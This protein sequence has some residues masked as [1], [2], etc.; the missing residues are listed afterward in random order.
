TISSYYKYPLDKT[1]LNLILDKSF[2][3]EKINELSE[4]I[5]DENY[6]NFTINEK[7]NEIN[8][9][10]DADTFNLI[11]WQNTDIYQNFNITFFSSIKKNEFISKNLFKLPSQN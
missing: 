1:P 11:G 7:D 6:I 9:F 5:V 3:I 2:L 4:R 8:I 10:F